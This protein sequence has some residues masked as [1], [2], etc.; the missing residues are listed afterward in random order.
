MRSV[1]R[2]RWLFVLFLL[3]I[4]AATFEASQHESV[5]NGFVNILRE[6]WGLATFTDV[7][8]A[9]LT[10]YVWLAYREVSWLKRIGWLFA[11]LFLGNIAISS[12]LIWTISRLPR[13]A[14]IEDLLLRPTGQRALA[15]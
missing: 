12:Y 14:K 10:F 4:L 2:L 6:P 13:G 7:Y 11:I 8:L 3:L 5:G 15:A 1:S 9:F